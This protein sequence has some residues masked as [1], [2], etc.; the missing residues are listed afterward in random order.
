MEKVEQAKEESRRI[1][2]EYK[3]VESFCKKILKQGNTRDQVLF[4]HMAKVERELAAN[5][6]NNRDHALF[7]RIN[8]LENELLHWNQKGEH[9]TLSA[10]GTTHAIEELQNEV[11]TLSQLLH[12]QTNQIGPTQCADET[13]IVQLINKHSMMDPNV[14]QD[15]TQRMEAAQRKLDEAQG[16]PTMTDERVVVLIKDNFQEGWVWSIANHMLPTKKKIK[17][18]CREGYEEYDKKVQQE[19]YKTY[20]EMFDKAKATEMSLEE[21]SQLLLDAKE[22]V[23]A[24]ILGQVMQEL[25]KLVDETKTN[26]QATV[27]DAVL[28]EMTTTVERQHLQ[29]ASQVQQR[30]ENARTSQDQEG[31]Q[32]EESRNGSNGKTN[33]GSGNGTEGQGSADNGHSG[34]NPNPDDGDDDKKPHHSGYVHLQTRERE[35]LHIS[36]MHTPN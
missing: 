32:P 10:T 6:L 17:D 24:N 3:T 29:L 30:L 19:I 7:D 25:S 9:D 13:R 1:F 14:L 12:E 20:T 4:D 21:R 23:Q 2:R 16:Q 26:V 36:R 28:Q 8:K 27:M 18:L 31:A 15:L 35:Q 5:N 34:N 33:Q 22:E 11:A